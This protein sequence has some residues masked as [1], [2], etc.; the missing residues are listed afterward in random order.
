LRLLV[1]GNLAL[2]GFIYAYT[3]WNEKA[4]FAEELLRFAPNAAPYLLAGVGLTAI[5]FT[6]AIDLSIGAIIVMAGTVFGIL[7]HHG[8]AP[9][10]CFAACFGT[11]IVL[12]LLNG[13]LVQ[14]LRI[15]AIIVTLAGLT[16]YRG[17]ALLLAQAAIPSFAGQITVQGDAYHSPGRDY[18]FHILLGGLAIAF[19]WEIFGKKPRE[20]LA[21]GSSRE[22]CRL[23][24]LNPDAVMLTA[25]LAG[26]F[27]LGLAALVSVTNQLTIEPSRMARSFEL[28]VI[29]AIVL[30]GTN[31]FGGEG[32][33]FGTV[34][35]GTFLYFVGQAM[36]YA[37]VSEFWRTALQGGVIVTVIGID[38]LLHR[39]QKLLEE[40]R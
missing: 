6:G 30:G 17:A 40:L 5:I 14:L 8:A 19:L 16:F 29:G 27:F 10:W 11:T 32:S 31:I 12:S 18:A 21:L 24:G 39:R 13:Y 2:L 25:F 26:G 4:S 34:L 20:W 23:K 3:L 37:G 28:Y 15:P 7:Y 38:C 36:L 35:G 1:V 22:A 33:F 9:G